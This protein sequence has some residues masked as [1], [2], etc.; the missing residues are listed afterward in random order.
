ME[1]FWYLSNIKEPCY[2][3]LCT[4]IH[5]FVMNICYL[6]MASNEYLYNLGNMKWTQ[7]LAINNCNE[8]WRYT[9]L[10]LNLVIWIY[11]ITQRTCIV[12]IHINI[13]CLI[14]T[15]LWPYWIYILLVKSTLLL[16]IEIDSL[17][18]KTYSQTPIWIL[19]LKY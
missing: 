17:T 6:E 10:T 13:Q 1:T 5:N 9:I 15:T 16:I 12:Y 4:E 14:H 11:H 19:Y 8:L 7:C 2:L 18:P 3:C